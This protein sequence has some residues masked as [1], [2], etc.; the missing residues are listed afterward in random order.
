MCRIPGPPCLGARLPLEKIDVQT[1]RFEGAIRSLPPQVPHVDH[2]FAAEY[3]SRRNSTFSSSSQ[4]SEDVD[5]DL[6][7]PTHLSL[8]SNLSEPAVAPAGPK[9]N[10]GVELHADLTGQSCTGY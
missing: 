5:Q 6:S 2:Y 1:G 3:N 10:I 8:G 9:K 7:L 4:G